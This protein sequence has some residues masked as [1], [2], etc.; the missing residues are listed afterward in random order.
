MSPTKPDF[1][2]KKPL[3]RAARASVPT[4][5]GDKWDSRS[6]EAAKLSYLLT[7]GKIP[8]HVTPS[9]VVKEFAPE[10]RRFKFCSVRSFIQKVRDSMQMQEGKY[11]CYDCYRVY[12]VLHA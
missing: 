11:F 4:L 9:R 10:Y 2:D 7:S 3:A 6:E 8:K 12:V 1:S 5:Q